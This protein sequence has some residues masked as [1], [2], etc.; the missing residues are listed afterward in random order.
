MTGTSRCDVVEGKGTQVNGGN[1]DVGRI[2]RNSPRARRGIGRGEKVK[3][4]LTHVVHRILNGHIFRHTSKHLCNI[5]CH[6][7]GAAQ[8]RKVS[9]E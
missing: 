6:E 3:E 1:G 2:R 7:E 8:V 5:I 4:R 9:D